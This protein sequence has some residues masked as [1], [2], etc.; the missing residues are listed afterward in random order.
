[1]E[2]VKVFAWIAEPDNDL[3]SLRV[4][5]VPSTQ[6]AVPS[7]PSCSG[8]YKWHKS[9]LIRHRRA[10]RAAGEHQKGS[11]S[12]ISRNYHKQLTVESGQWPESRDPHPRM[13]SPMY[14]TA[15][16]RDDNFQARVLAASMMVG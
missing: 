15:P 4:R 5:F 1:M 9:I 14:M 13:L 8:L 3:L 12:Q 7:L 10:L 2:I 6:L 11:L 16:R